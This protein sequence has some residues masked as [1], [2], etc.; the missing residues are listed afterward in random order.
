MKKLLIPFLVLVVAA[1]HHAGK[2]LYDSKMP[3]ISML[4][5]DSATR[6]K[7]A[8][9]P[10]GEPVVFIY[11]RPDCIHCQEET[12]MLLQG[13]AS[14]KDVRLYMLT[15]KYHPMLKAFYEHFKLGD[16]D[17]IKVG[18]DEGMVF[19]NHFQARHIPFLAVFDKDKR[20]VKAHEGT[21]TLNSLL[22]TVE[23]Q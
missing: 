20:L 5:V 2:R 13:I 1:C 9:I 6:I 19:F 18:V 8:D 10:G 11:F 3:A 4:L 22:Q 21:F 16:Y 7:A 17:N 14:L 15:P 23:E 12:N